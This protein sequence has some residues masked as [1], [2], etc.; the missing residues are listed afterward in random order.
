MQQTLPGTTIEVSSYK[1]DVADRV[2]TNIFAAGGIVLS[3]MATLTGLEPHTVQN[4]VKRGFLAPPVHRLYSKRQFTRVVLINMLRDSMKIDHIVDLLTFVNGELKREDD[5]RIDDSVL[6]NLFVNLRARMEGELPA[7]KS[8]D[9]VC[10]TLLASFE[11]KVPD[12]RRRI[13]RVLMVMVYAWISSR[14]KQTA[15]VLMKDLN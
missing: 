2:L 6:Y 15:E 4:W 1:E 3:Q 8:L 10:D 14:A 13:K 7:Q 5:D 11:E 9:L 12:S